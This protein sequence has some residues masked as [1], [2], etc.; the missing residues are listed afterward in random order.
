MS[1]NKLALAVLLIYSL[2]APAFGSEANIQASKIPTVIRPAIEKIKDSKTPLMLPTWLP[3]TCA[4]PLDT[5]K[6]PFQDGYELWLG[7]CSADTTFFTS[8]GKGKATKTKHA[9]KL[10]NGK[11]AYIQNLKDFCLEWSDN[12]NVYRVGYP[13]KGA[14]SDSAILMKIANS[15]KFVDSK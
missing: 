1:F 9:I 10:M 6:G 4:G 12:G 14:K 5:G 2:N 3:S 8:A 7:T 15:M 11:T 13:S